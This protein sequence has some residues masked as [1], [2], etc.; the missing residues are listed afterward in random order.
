MRHRVGVWY[1][2]VQNNIE[3]SL[4]EVKRGE[5]GW[6]KWFPESEDFLHMD[7]GPKFEGMVFVGWFYEEAS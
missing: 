7:N 1:G 6:W 4:H 2:P 5:R 3:L